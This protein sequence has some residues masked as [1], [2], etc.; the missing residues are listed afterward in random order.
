MVTRTCRSE[1]HDLHRELWLLA[2]VGVS[3]ILDCLDLIGSQ[4][5]VLVSCGSMRGLF[6]TSEIFESYV[7]SGQIMSESVQLNLCV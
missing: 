7:V 6:V 2:R 5:M 4:G 3:D 1:L